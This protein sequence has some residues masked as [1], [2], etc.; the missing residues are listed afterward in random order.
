MNLLEGHRQPEVSAYLRL[1]AA[2]EP[3][4]IFFKLGPLEIGLPASFCEELGFFCTPDG[5]EEAGSW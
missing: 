1:L 3:T 5:A 2:G 4:S